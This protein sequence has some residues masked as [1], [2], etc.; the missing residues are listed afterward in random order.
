MAM[1]AAIPRVVQRT[2]AMALCLSLPASIVDLQQAVGVLSDVALVLQGS[3]TLRCIVAQLRGDCDSAGM[4]STLPWL[5][6]AKVQGGRSALQTFALRLAAT[7]ASRA[8]AAHLATGPE[9]GSLGRASRVRLDEVPARLA[10]AG[11]SL[12]FIQA[13]VESAGLLQAHAAIIDVPSVGHSAVAS[14]CVKQP[15]PSITNF[16]YTATAALETAAVALERAQ[17]GLRSAIDG[18][19]SATSSDDAGPR[20][21]DRDTVSDESVVGGLSLSVGVSTPAPALVDQVVSGMYDVTATVR[22]AVAAHPA[23]FS[24]LPDEAS[25]AMAAMTAGT[26]TPPQV[27]RLNPTHAGPPESAQNSPSLPL[28]GTPIRRSFPVVVTTSAMARFR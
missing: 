6:V 21:R 12:R 20:E 24:S 14:S 26:C 2:R 16:L 13:E 11:A 25:A 10:S 15:E 18:L 22:K 27:P 4:V 17:C 9:Y 1:L 5:L 3:S 28:A 23:F 7:P 19:L 8:A